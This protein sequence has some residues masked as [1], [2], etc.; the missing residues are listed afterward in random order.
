VLSVLVG[1][2][3]KKSSVF[4]EH[5]SY[6]GRYSSVH[7]SQPTGTN[8][9]VAGQ[10]TSGYKNLLSINNENNKHLQKAKMA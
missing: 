10:H 5:A 6:F 3:F 1:A 7:G 8:T 2:L 4:M 9:A